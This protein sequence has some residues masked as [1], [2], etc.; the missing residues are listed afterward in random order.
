M[1]KCKD[2]IHN[3][4]CRSFLV[5][6]HCKEELDAIA[7]NPNASR[8][9]NYKDK[10]SV[11]SLPCKVGDTVYYLEITYD[12]KPKIVVKEDVVYSF[13]IKGDGP[14]AILSHHVTLLPL[15]DFGETVFLSREDA[16]K[17]LEKRNNC[18]GSIYV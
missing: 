7:N 18:R 9:E 4:A 15:D 12:E 1:A 17:A 8:C 3:E 13:I 14:F 11:V 2:C 6:T 16:E 5:V 10:D